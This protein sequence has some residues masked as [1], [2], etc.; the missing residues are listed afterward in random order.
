MLVLLFR[1]G[2]EEGRVSQGDPPFLE[3]PLLRW[4][5][6]LL[7]SPTFPAH[8]EPSLDASHWYPSAESLDAG[9][10]D[11]IPLSSGPLALSPSTSSYFPHLGHLGVGRLP[12]LGIA[13]LFLWNP[14]TPPIHPSVHPDCLGPL[15]GWAHLLST[16]FTCHGSL[17]PVPTPATHPKCWPGVRGVVWAGAGLSSPHAV[18]Y[19]PVPSWSHSI[20]EHVPPPTSLCFAVIDQ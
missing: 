20:T 11:T 19:P 18:L 9:F 7:G 6:P 1:G 12:T 15:A 3:T 14:P 8:Q 13:P 16:W 10:D 2:R 4:C 5:T 17:Y